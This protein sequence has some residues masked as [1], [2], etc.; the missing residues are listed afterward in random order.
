MTTVGL[1]T[2]PTAQAA[3]SPECQIESTFGDPCQAIEDPCRNGDCIPDPPP[4]DVTVNVNVCDPSCE[5][6]Q[7]VQV[8]PPSFAPFDVPDIWLN[9]CQIT[10]GPATVNIT[11]ASIEDSC[12]VGTKLR[13]V[14]QIVTP[15][16]FTSDGFEPPTTVAS[17]DVGSCLVHVGASV[18]GNGADV[19]D[20]VPC[21]RV[22]P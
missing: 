19:K 5:T 18:A 6:I 16:A 20:R 22:Q 9:L 11:Q 7:D 3:K 10:I 2:V 8:A 15:D 14:Q 13:T 21:A 17:L 1:A 12:I 4:H